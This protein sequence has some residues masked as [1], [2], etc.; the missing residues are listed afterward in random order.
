MQPVT[1]DMKKI[2][3]YQ[4]AYRSNVFIKSK[5]GKLA[6]IKN[7]KEICRADIYKPELVQGKLYSVE[8]NTFTIVDLSSL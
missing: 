1:T 7:S 4:F 3:R 2:W 8:K 6:I 5:L